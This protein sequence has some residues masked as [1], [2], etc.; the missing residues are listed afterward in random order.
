MHVK[1]AVSNRT[2]AT[3]LPDYQATRLPDYQTTKL[4]DYQTTRL[5]QT[6]RLPDYHARLP[7]CQT[8]RHQDRTPPYRKAR[9]VTLHIT[10]ALTWMHQIPQDHT[11][12]RAVC[13]ANAQLQICRQAGMHR[14][15]PHHKVDRL[16]PD[17]ARRS[18]VGAYGVFR[19]QCST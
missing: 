6:T 8:T 2:Q 13:A 17:Q 10:I 18:Q 7:D 12:A 3:R 9:A 14:S 15:G 1:Q 19:I 16:P 5:N 4:S 11:P